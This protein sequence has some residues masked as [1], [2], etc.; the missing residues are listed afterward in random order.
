MFWLYFQSTKELVCFYYKPINFP[1]LILPI[2][3]S[4]ILFF[5]SPPCG[6][7]ILYLHPLKLMTLNAVFILA[8]FEKVVFIIKRH[9]IDFEKIVL[10]NKTLK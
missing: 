4:M 5:G 8:R 7:P 6:F 9:T 2:L 3:Q 1:F 10:V